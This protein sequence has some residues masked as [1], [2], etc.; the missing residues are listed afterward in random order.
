MNIAEHKLN[1]FR[2]IDQL[3]D[4]L[5]LEL[6]QIISKLCFKRIKSNSLD[7][8]DLIS[9]ESFLKSR[10][11]AAEQ[12]EVIN[13]SV[14]SIF[15]EV[16]EDYERLISFLDWLIDQVGEDERHSLASLMEI[17]GV[18]IERYEDEHVPELNSTK[19]Y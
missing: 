12:G 10:I 7:S 16:N 19:A 3:P 2:K 1:L 14:L 8:N 9:L 18:L 6:E 11:E 4:E 13:K 15:T 17:V 5:L